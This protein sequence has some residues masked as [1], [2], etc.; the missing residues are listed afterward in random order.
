MDSWLIRLVNLSGGI[1]I[2]LVVFSFVWLIRLVN[3]SGGILIRLVNS[4]GDGWG[5]IL[6]R[7]V[8]SSG[9]RGVDQTN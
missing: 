4:S 9:A 6:I 5:G 2:R 3:S 1:L 7:R 8:N